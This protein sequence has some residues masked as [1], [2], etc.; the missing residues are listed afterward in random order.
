MSIYQIS[1]PFLERSR[2]E[3]DRYY[4]PDGLTQAL[5]ERVRICGKVYEPCVGDGAIARH[6]KN[7]R[8]NDIDRSVSADT[9]HDVLSQNAWG[10][11]PD[12]VVSNPPFAIA[13]KV[14]QYA[15]NDA[16]VGVALLLRTTFDEPTPTN[17]R[18]QL[19]Q[20]YSDCQT[21]KIVFGGPR[22]DFTGGGGDSATV[23]WYVWQFNHS[24]TALNVDPPFQY[25]TGWDK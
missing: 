24:W 2:L 3:L 11:S 9:H 15:F 7:I 20:H 4:S 18:A 19:L 5:I 12:W 16:R 22:P 1:M 8:T 10:Y 17:G 13:T 21:H 25:I 6:F 14:L 23:A